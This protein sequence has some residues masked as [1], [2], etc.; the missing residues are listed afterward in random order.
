MEYIRL[1]YFPACRMVT[2]GKGFFGDENFTRFEKLLAMEQK[3]APYP[4]DFLTGDEHGMEWLYLYREGMDTLGMEVVDF[5]GGLYAVVC[6]IDA[7]SN[8]AEMAAVAEF[9]EQHGLVR[10]DSRPDLGNIIGD[11]RTQAV[12]GYEQMDYFTPVKKKEEGHE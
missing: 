7:Q 10:D 3:N 8:A 2:S 11:A 9:M 6:G 1:Q 5:P 12:L 4:S